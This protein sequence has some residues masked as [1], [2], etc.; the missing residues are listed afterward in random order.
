MKREGIIDIT[1]GGEDYRFE[2]NDELE[3]DVH[4]LDKELAQQAARYAWFSVLLERARDEFRELE[5]EKQ[6]LDAK[7]DGEIRIDFEKAQIKTTE[8]KV[9][10]KIKA[11]PARRAL[12]KKIRKMEFTCG[13]LLS[14]VMGYAQRKDLIV[15]LSRSRGVEASSMSHVEADRIKDRFRKRNQNQD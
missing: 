11:H 3:I 13:V 5:A 6:E 4:D 12:K 8:A 14:I 7:L 1:V 9:S 15:S 2:V 10:A